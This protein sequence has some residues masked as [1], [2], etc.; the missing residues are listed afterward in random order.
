MSEGKIDPKKPILWNHIDEVP[1]RW[2]FQGDPIGTA[3]IEYEEDDSGLIKEMTVQ[4]EVTD[5]EILKHLALAPAYEVEARDGV[6]IT[7]C[8]L[9]EVSLVADSANTHTSPVF[10]NLKDGE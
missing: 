3:K 9:L 4:V 2:N 10:K 1:L 5:S 8:K 7:K 6:V